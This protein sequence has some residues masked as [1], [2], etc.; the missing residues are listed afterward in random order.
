METLKLQHRT[1]TKINTLYKRNLESK[2]HEIIPGEY[3]DPEVEYLKDLLWECYLKVDGTNMHYQWDG[4][5]LEI[6]GKTERAN[7]PPKLKEVMNNLV[8]KEMME[9]EFP[10]KY[11]EN[12]NEIPMMVRIYGEGCGQGI[13]KCGKAY[14]PKSNRFVVFDVLIDN[15]WLNRKDVEDICNR[16]NLE[17]VPL[18]GT[19]T[20]TEAEQLVKQGFKDTIAKTD[21][22]AEG[23]VCRPLF[24]IKKRNG[25]R[26][27]TKIKKCDYDLLERVVNSSLKF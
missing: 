5:T 4:H 13:Q 19:M 14:D 21:L 3:S 6:H 26:I 12:G 8:T 18:I 16:L 15:W 11:D 7:I 25:E 27:I 20:I 22:E 24:G 23:L 2:N 10:L 9:E 17:I 1:Y